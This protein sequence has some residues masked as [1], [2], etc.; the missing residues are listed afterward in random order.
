M[1]NR[2]SM[3]LLVSIALLLGF[4]T[5][6]ASQDSLT[7]T[8]TSADGM[9]T[10][11]Y[12]DGW[13]VTEEDTL[14]RFNAD[15]AFLQVSYR[16]YGDE[17][18]PLEVLEV[19]ALPALGFSEPEDLVIAGYAA[20]QSISRDQWQT[21][22][23]FCGGTLGL[24]YGFVQ[25]GEMPIYEPTFTAMVDSIRFGEGEAQVCRGA[26]EGL[27]PITPAN[28]AGITPLTTLGDADVAVGS[29]LF[30]ADGGLLAAGMADG[31]VQVWSMVTGEEVVTLSGHRDGATS[32]AFTSGGYT[33]ATGAGSGQVRTWDASTGEGL[34]TLPEHDAA[35]R[36]IAMGGPYGFLVASGAD[37]GVHLWDISR[38]AEASLDDSDALPVSSVAFTPDGSILAAGGGSTIR[39][40]DTATGTMR[41]TLE[42]TVSDI[43]SIIFM[44]DSGMLVYGGADASVWLWDLANDPQPVPGE[45][46]PPVSALA[47]SPDSAILAIGDAAGVQL[48]DMATGATLAT[49]PTPSGEVVSSVA[50]SAD[51]SLVA[52]GSATGG[53][54]L[55]A[56]SGDESA[57]QAS[58]PADTGSTNAATTGETT[59]TGAGGTAAT[60]TIT[61]P[62]NANLR[63][64]PGT[65]FDRAGA[66]SA[67][68]T[69]EIDGQST[70]PDGFV[71]YRLADGT[72]ARSDV[73]GTPADCTGVPTVT[74]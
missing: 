4:P 41:A 36:S 52:T 61:A 43:S 38:R 55:W 37:D 13:T 17:V 40:W 29:V 23:N 8:F 57:S 71:W 62:G 12:P 68:Q 58:A 9:L 33:M 27:V 47:L 21:V 19:G 51:G 72:W 39:L 31:T 59:P 5:A 49:L 11:S 7:Q 66:L 32:I 63:A 65:N 53:V 30:S 67:G 56:A 50:F 69:I 54:I 1:R 22:I 14:I 35:V 28:A 3:I 6:V 16:N 26:F 70:A 25:P 64:G 73:L 10:M 74:P 2:L 42:T 15:R 48:R 60:C 18:T 45:L 34:G 46:E 44:A 24:A 20:V